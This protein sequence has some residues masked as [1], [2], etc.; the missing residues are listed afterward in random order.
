MTDC[1]TDEDCRLPPECASDPVSCTPKGDRCS[2]DGRCIGTH[3]TTIPGDTIIPTSTV[4][5]EGWDDAPGSGPVFLLSE[6]S[7][8]PQE[9]VTSRGF[10]FKNYLYFFGQA[11]NAKIQQGVNDGQTLIL[12]EIAGLDPKTYKGDDDSVTVK[13]YLA[14]DADYPPNPANNACAG[15]DCGKFK[16]SPQSYTMV[17]GKPQLRSRAAAKIKDGQLQTVGVIPGL[18]FPLA[19]GPPPARDVFVQ[20]PVLL[21]RIPATLKALESGL[22]HGAVLARDLHKIPDPYCLAGATTD[23]LSACPDVPSSLLD[24]GKRLVQSLQPD[25]RVGG[26]KPGCFALGSSGQVIERCGACP[27]PTDDCD[28]TSNVDAFSITMQLGGTRA[29]IVN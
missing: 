5:G 27:S 21:T 19:I 4:T 23:E 14:E 16:I 7:I 24:L 26:G 20:T 8:S 17:D 13:F 2:G 29:T 9:R 3:Q 12:M 18:V 6:V 25:V 28:W 10:S 15:P 22:L 1:Y 11:S